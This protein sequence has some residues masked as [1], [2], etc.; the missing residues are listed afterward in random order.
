Y[1]RTA[2][3]AE[4]LEIKA[5]FDKHKGANSFLWDS[6]LDGEVRVKAGDYQP[7]CL[8]GDT[9]RITTTFTQVFYP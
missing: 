2:K 3:K 1:Q 8:G 5:F 4:I 7:V 9:W 6:P